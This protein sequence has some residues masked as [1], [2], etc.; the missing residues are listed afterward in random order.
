MFGIILRVLGNQ[1]KKKENSGLTRRRI[2]V[3]DTG[4]QVI[5]NHLLCAW[6]TFDGDNEQDR[7]VRAR[8]SV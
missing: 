3:Y 1:A 8:G 5:G 4:Q 7:V 6:E 2:L